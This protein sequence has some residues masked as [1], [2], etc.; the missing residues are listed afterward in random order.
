MGVAAF[1]DFVGNV[2][3]ALKTYGL[4]DNTLLIM[5]SDNGAV[6]AAPQGPGRWHHPEGKG[7]VASAGGTA[8]PLRSAKFNV[9]EGGTRVPVIMSGGAMPA[10]CAGKQSHAL[11]HVSDWYATLAAAAGVPDAV[12]IS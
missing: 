3:A 4:W 11:M 9:W 12:V 2:T 6:Q 8:Y 5:H 10:R 1:D 7:S